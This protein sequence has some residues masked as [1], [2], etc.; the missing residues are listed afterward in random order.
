MDFRGQTTA[1]EFYQ[2]Y[3]TAVISLWIRK[4]RPRHR[5]D[6]IPESDKNLQV[7]TRKSIHDIDTHVVDYD[8]VVIIRNSDPGS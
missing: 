6:L 2:G 8:M 4:S 5:N 1:S 3:S 7:P